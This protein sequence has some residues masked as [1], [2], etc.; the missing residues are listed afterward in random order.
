MVVSQHSCLNTWGLLKCLFLFTSDPLF[1]MM[2]CILG[3]RMDIVEWA[4]IW[5]R[6]YNCHE[7]PSLPHL[8]PNK[9][10]PD[11]TCPRSLPY[12]KSNSYQ[13]WPAINP[14]SAM[15]F[16]SSKK[17]GDS[18]TALQN[19]GQVYSSLQIARSSK[20]ITKGGFSKCF[21]VLFDSHLTSCFPGVCITKAPK[22]R[23][24]VRLQHLGVVE[25]VS[26]IHTGWIDRPGQRWLSLPCKNPVLRGIWF[27]GDALSHFLLSMGDIAWLTMGQ[28]LEPC[29]YGM[30]KIEALYGGHGHMAT[31]PDPNGW[32]D[33]WTHKSGTR[34]SE[35]L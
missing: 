26:S 34:T 4:W 22:H 33:A 9:W 32:E 17:G 13:S 3:W 10:P 2:G 8:L 7:K 15:T 12:S 11:S 16:F 30:Q 1:H 21:Q 20:V 31:L 28:S 19:R 23:A 35:K 5:Q 29:P 14:C 27:T 25:V 24:L 6:A 18:L